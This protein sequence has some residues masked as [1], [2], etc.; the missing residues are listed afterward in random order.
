MLFFISFIKPKIKNMEMQR[1]TLT[2][3]MRKN[4]VSPEL[5]NLGFKAYDYLSQQGDTGAYIWEMNKRL[6][7]TPVMGWS[8]ART[9][10]Q[11]AVDLFTGYGVLEKK[12]SDGRYRPRMV[13][14]N[15]EE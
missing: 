3:S 10:M 15:P 7:D 14:I 12:A 11:T 6:V 5:I 8:D 1:T 2:E 9:K 4:N 13:L